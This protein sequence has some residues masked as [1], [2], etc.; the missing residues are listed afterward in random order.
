MKYHGQ[1]LHQPAVLVTASTG[2]AATRINGITKHSAF[3]LPNCKLGKQ[4]CSR[5]PSDE[6]LNKKCY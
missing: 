6:E 2:K 5:N 1:N 3:N 4:F